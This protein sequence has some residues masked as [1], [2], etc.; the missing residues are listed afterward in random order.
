MQRID[1]TVVADVACS[2]SRAYLAYLRASGYRPRK[3]LLVDYAAPPA[4]APR[5]RLDRLLG[6]RAATLVRRLLRPAPPADELFLECCEEMQS[7]HAVRV[8][9]FGRFDWSAHADEIEACGASGYSDPAFQALLRRQPGA[10]LYT[11]GDRVP[12]EL[13]ADPALRIL[14][15][16]PG[17]V[18][19]MRG[20]DGLLWSLA[21]RGKPGASCFYMDAG[22]DSGAVIATR[23]FPAPRFPRLAR[24]LDAHEATLYRALVH[25]YDPHLRGQMLVDVVRASGGRS[26]RE[27]PSRPQPADAGRWWFAMH[28]RLRRKVLAERVL[29]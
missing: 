13:T 12:P 10:L 18:P 2:T 29:C 6:R 24:L 28:P 1:L 27:L 15:I 4:P 9:Y 7:G 20:S 11:C 17:V 23:E 5:G 26:L 14:H 16:H 22:I 21:V 25:A 19:A 3:V 8:D